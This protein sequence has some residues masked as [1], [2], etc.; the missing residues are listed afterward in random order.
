[1]WYLPWRYGKC[2]AGGLRVARSISLVKLVLGKEIL[3]SSLCRE[4]DLTLD[5]PQ[6]H[7]ECL[8]KRVAGLHPRVSDLV[9][10]EWGQRSC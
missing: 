10:L 4:V 1:M 2:H 3:G 9:S 5:M 7:L 6:N 8:L